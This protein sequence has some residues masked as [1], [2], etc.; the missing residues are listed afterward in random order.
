MDDTLKQTLKLRNIHYIVS[1]FFVGPEFTKTNHRVFLACH[2]HVT[3]VIRL[4]VQG[5][6]WISDRFNPA[7]GSGE[8]NSRENSGPNLYQRLMTRHFKGW[9]N[10]FSIFCQHAENELFNHSLGKDVSIQ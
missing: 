7:S 3:G 4:Q 9:L 2:M 8:S 5:I 10:L 6:R 1:E